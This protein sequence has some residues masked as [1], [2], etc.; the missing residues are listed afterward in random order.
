MND[1]PLRMV[2]EQLIGKR[3]AV[4][5]SL[6]GQRVKTFSGIGED[7]GDALAV[8]CDGFAFHFEKELW[9]EFDVRATPGNGY[10]FIILVKN[11]T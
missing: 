3:V 7:K 11:A 10:E 4:R 6:P 1:A 2:P 5:V 8:E 9:R